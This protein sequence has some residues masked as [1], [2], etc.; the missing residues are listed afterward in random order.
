MK[1]E[2]KFSLDY[3]HSST[4]LDFQNLAV[5]Y[6]C[7]PSPFHMHPSLPISYKLFSISLKIIL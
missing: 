1:S 5:S 7:L 3:L 6:L 4:L 2:K